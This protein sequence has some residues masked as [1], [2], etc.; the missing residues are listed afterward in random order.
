[1]NPTSRI[2]SR[3]LSTCFF[4]ALALTAQTTSAIPIVNLDVTQSGA[5]YHYEV[6]IDN[7]EAVDLI[8]VSLF[9]TPLSDALIT[10]SLTAP[11]GFLASYDSGL[12]IIDFLGNTSDFLPGT[13]TSG[14]S[15]DSVFAP[16]GFFTDV[17]A[18]DGLLTAYD[19]QVKVNLRTVP[20]SGGSLLLLSLSLGALAFGRM[21]F[22]TVNG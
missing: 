21:K 10:A 6:S 7:G 1:M 11:A 15:F 5:N 18:Y 19:G 12:G 16:A 4:L 13:I 2:Q 3:V 20:D 9:N 17:T 8:L 22:S 14:F